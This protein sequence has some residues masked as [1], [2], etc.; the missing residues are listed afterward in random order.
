M[1]V[2]TEM[3]IGRDSLPPCALTVVLVEALAV[4]VVLTDTLVDTVTF[5]F[6]AFVG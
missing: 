4:V 5:V 1:Q 6:A 2:M 3:L